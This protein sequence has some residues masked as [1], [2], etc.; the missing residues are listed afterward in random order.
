M[1][2]KCFRY[3]LIKY[4]FWDNIRSLGLTSKA[5]FARGFNS[6]VLT[7]ESFSAQG[8]LCLVLTVSFLLNLR[9]NWLPE[10]QF[11]VHFPINLM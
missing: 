10:P 7:C 8:R 9:T 5:G 6:G 2:K 1:A 3:V 4:G 11:L